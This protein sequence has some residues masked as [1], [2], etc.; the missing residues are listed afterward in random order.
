MR[1]RSTISRAAS[2]ERRLRLT[3]MFHRESLRLRQPYLRF[4]ADIGHGQR[5][6][7]SWWAS[8]FASRSPLHTDF[9]AL[10]CDGSIA[11][12]LVARRDRRDGLVVF[13]DDPWL[14]IGLKQTLA[15]AEVRFVGPRFPLLRP[16]LAC[17]LRGS[18]YRV[19]LAGYLTAAWAVATRSFGRRPPAA[20]PPAVAIVSFLEARSMQADRFDDPYLGRL[21]DFLESRGFSVLRVLYPLG[22]LGLLPRARRLRS[23]AWPLI[24]EIRPRHFAQL[25]R[26][27]HP[28]TDTPPPIDGI[29]PAVLECLMRREAWV[30]FSRIAFNLHFVIRDLFVQFLR[31]GHVGTLVYFFENHPW[32]KMMCLAAR[33][34][35]GVRALGHQHAVVPWLQLRYFLGDGEAAVMPLPDRIVTNGPRATMLL[36]ESAGYPRDIVVEGGALRY[37]YLVHVTPQIRSRAAQQVVLAALPADVVTART[38]LAAVVEA[39]RDSRASGWA[40]VVKPHPDTDLHELGSRPAGPAVTITSVPFAQLLDEAGLVVASGSTIVEAWLRGKRVLHV[41][42]ECRLDLDLVDST[43]LPGVEVA[44]ED[45]LS[46]AIAESLAAGTPGPEAAALRNNTF[47]SAVRYDVWLSE[48]ERRR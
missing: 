42:Y 46:E 12:K 18:A 36:G 34:V 40:F 5:D 15:G 33:E 35:G 26:R 6:L 30:E 9:F 1:L 24:R 19:L 27:W 31:R 14:F 29:D 43:E 38:M 21:D 37:G 25:L 3:E 11:L 17:L 22:P 7:A 2:A 20:A 45:R 44:D 32:E 39:S 4:V 10:L 13:V 41:R 16:T 48:I 28:D 23:A 47:F 8:N